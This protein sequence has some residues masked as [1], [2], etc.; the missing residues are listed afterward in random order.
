MFPSESIETRD[1]ETR[2]GVRQVTNHDSIHHHPFFYVPAYDDAMTWLFFVSHRSGSPQFFAERRADGEL[3]Q[4]TDR[5]DLN[6]WSL[7]PSHNGEY[8]YYT[9]T[10]GGWRLGLD[11]LHEEQIVDF[12]GGQKS[13]EWS[14]QEWGQRR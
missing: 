10:E 13:P 3:I 11:S 2:A 5:D 4:L 8:L 14:A 12:A 9:T 7:H 1:A 6:E